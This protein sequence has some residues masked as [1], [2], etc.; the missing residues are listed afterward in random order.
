MS[1]PRKPR[2]PAA[3]HG[4][5]FKALRQKLAKQ[6]RR[7]ADDRD[8]VRLGQYVLQEQLL[9]TRQIGG[10]VIAAVEFSEIAALVDKAR[11]ALSPTNNEIK[12]FIIK[13]GEKPIEL[14]DLRKQTAA[15]VKAG[16]AAAQSDSPSVVPAGR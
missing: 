9:V 14:E 13:K 6:Y 2:K 4:A 12:V 3:D 1:T 5:T 7:K 11:E 10:E 16:K 15:K 8:I